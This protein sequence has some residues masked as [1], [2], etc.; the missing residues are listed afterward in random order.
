M[1]LK[2]RD[3]LRGAGERMAYTPLF[4]RVFALNAVVLAVAVLLTIVVLPPRVLKAPET[5]EEIA[6]L[7]GSL[8]L[9][10]RSTCCS[11]ARRLL[12]SNGLPK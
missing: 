9:S 1:T 4:W 10:S 8:G 7:A 6:I 11:C 12:P 5:E 2:A 3:Q